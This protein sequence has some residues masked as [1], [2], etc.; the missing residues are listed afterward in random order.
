MTDSDTIDDAGAEAKQSRPS[1]SSKKPVILAVDDD[2]QV[3]AAIARDLRR[4]YA[5]RFRIV[6]AA[7]GRSALDT[8]EQLTLAGSPV[9]LIIT[10]QRM[11]GVTGVELLTT[12]REG[13]PGARMVLLTAYADTDAAIKAINEV[14]LDQ[15]I[16]KPWDPPEDRLY[17][18]LD[19]ILD[20]WEASY[21]PP[22]E[23]IRLVGHRWSSDSHRLRDFLSRNLVPFRWLDVDLAAEEAANLRAAAHVDDLPLVVFPDGSHKVAPSNRDLGEAIGLN[24]NTETKSFDLLVIGAGPAGLAAAVYGASEGLNTAVLESTAPGG[25]AGTSSRIEN[26]LGFPTGVSGAAPFAARP[27]PGSAPRRPAHF[28]NP[29]DRPVSVGRLQIALARRRFDDRRQCRHRRQRHHLPQACRR[30]R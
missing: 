21:H 13:T 22:F 20:D 16:L 7:N 25:Q 15:Y 19:E 23:G 11:P 27:R 28:A 26:Y 2:P 6:R 4:H 12:A 10:D 8:L 3:L 5:E 30:R 24:P 9:A 1:K 17:P 18:I 14:R 29:R